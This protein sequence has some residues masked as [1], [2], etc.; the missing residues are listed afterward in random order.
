MKTILLEH[1]ILAHRHLYYSGE[2]VISDYEYD[3]IES[4]ARNLLPESSEVHSYGEVQR[5]IEVLKIAAMIKR[6]RF[7]AELLPMMKEL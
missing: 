7:I 6:G 3:K 2:A 4:A 5:N 1:L